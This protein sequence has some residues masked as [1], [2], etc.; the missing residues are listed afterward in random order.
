LNPPRKPF[1]PKI[2][3]S[4]LLPYDQEALFDLINQIESYPEFIPFCSKAAIIEQSDQHL[5]ASITLQKGPLHETFTTKNDLFSP[6]KMVLHLVNG[7]FKYLNGAWTFEAKG[8]CTLVSL[9]LDYDFNSFIVASVF[10][11]LFKKVASELMQNF[12]HYAKQVLDK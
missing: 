1:V 12:Q 5:T 10:G 7:P 4:A 11:A 6:E 8:D 9:N 3:Q 2:S